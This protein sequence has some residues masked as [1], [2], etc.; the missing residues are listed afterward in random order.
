MSEVDKTIK[1]HPERSDNR[2]ENRSYDNKH[3]NRNSGRNNN[4]KSYFGDN[5]MTMEVLIVKRVSC[6][7]AGGR[8][9]SFSANV[10]VGD[11]KGTIGIGDGKATEVPDAIN[12]AERHAKKHL[13]RIPMYRSTIMHDCSAEFGATK[14]LLKRAPEGTGVVACNALKTVC[15]TCGIKNIV[16]KIYGS[17]NTKNVLIAFQKAMKSCETPK[18]IAARRDKSLESIMQHNLKLNQTIVKK[19]D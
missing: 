4:L 17:K 3:N 10:V 16:I 2:G 13:F 14:I 18:R 19:E 1:V 12:K 8:R 5:E 9:Q 6:T 11:G 15:S 7:T